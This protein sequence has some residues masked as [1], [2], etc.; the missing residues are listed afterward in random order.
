MHALQVA[1]GGEFSQIAANRVL[2]HSKFAAQVLGD[3][4]A[5][6]F[7]RVENQLLSLRSEHG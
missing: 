4:L 7:E 6:T 5:V 1:I 2:R 3:H